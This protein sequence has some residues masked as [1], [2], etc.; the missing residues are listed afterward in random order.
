MSRIVS[1]LDH[2]HL[3]FSYQKIPADVRV[4]SEVFGSILADFV[5]MLSP[6]APCFAS[7][8]WAGLGSVAPQNSSYDW[9]SLYFGLFL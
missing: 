8:L 6:L 7:E 4:N 9:V 3:S 1:P 2:S 5:V